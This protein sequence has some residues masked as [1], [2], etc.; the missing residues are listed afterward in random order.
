MGVTPGVI[1]LIQATEV[2]K[3]IVGTGRLLTNRLYIYSG[4]DME[5]SEVAVKRKPDCP[6]C[7]DSPSIV[8]LVEDNYPTANV[9]EST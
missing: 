1:G 3:W 6:V 7:G 9:C 4:L 5:F 2:L 8:E